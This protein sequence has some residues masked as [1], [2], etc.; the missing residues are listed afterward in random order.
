[1][2]FFLITSAFMNP[3]LLKLSNPKSSNKMIVKKNVTVSIDGERNYYVNKN[4]IDVERLPEVVTS[5]L[6]K[7]ASDEDPAIIINAE[8]SVPVEDIVKVM[9]V[10]KSKNVKIVLQTQPE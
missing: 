8:K 9:N 5:E 6:N 7:I 1:M 10:G 4:K 2:L 3:N